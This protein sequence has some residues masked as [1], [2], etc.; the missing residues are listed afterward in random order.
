MG[1]KAEHANKKIPDVS[2][3]V[4]TTVLNLNI[5]SLYKKKT[6][7]VAK[8]SEIKKKKLKHDYNNKYVTTKK[9]NRL[10]AENYTASLKQAN[11][12]T[13]SDID[14]FVEKTGFDDKLRNLNKKVTSNKKNK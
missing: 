4:T 1:K 7:Y 8:L 3:L 6:D 5:G 2:G 13:K 11:F 12:A 10:L 14:D 9:F